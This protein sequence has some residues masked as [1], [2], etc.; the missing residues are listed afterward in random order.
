MTQ[1]S[2]ADDTR[3]YYRLTYRD[4]T[5]EQAVHNIAGRTV[6]LTWENGLRIHVNVNDLRPFLD[7][8]DYRLSRK[9]LLWGSL[10][11]HKK[12]PGSSVDAEPGAE[13]KP[14]CH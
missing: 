11:E 10:P 8:L 4:D 2:G 3:N 13:P 9:G 7:R 6:T 12:S 5:G 14:S 1:S